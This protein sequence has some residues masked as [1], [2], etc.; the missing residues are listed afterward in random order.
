MKITRYEKARLLGARALQVASGAPFLVK[1][2]D[3]ELKELKYNP[4]EIAK[5]ELEAGVLPIDVLK[6]TPKEKMA[7]RV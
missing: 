1:I 5:K 6:P 2:S 3:E 7:R 4:I